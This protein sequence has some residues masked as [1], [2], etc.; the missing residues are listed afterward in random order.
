MRSDV[1]FAIIASVVAF[2]VGDV[3]AGHAQATGS[4][5]LMQGGGFAET[6]PG[7][8][9]SGSVFFSDPLSLALGA[10][11]ACGV[12]L[13]WAK[14]LERRGSYRRGEEHGSSRWATQKEMASYS[15]ALHP[16]NNIILSRRSRKRFVDDVHDQ[17]TETNN[18]MLIVGGP[19][20]GKTRYYVKPNLYQLNSNYF[21]TDPKGTLILDVGWL[22]EEEGYDI[23]TFD[24]IDFTRS[25]HFNPI[26]YIRDEKGILKFVECLVKNTT[27]DKEHAG[28][29]FWENAEKLLYTALIG[30]LVAHCPPEDRNVGGLIMLLSLA[31]AREDDED[32]MSPLDMLF[33]EIET[34]KRLAAKAGGSAYDPNGRDFD[35]GNSSFEWVEIGKP[36]KPEQDFALSTY[37][38]FKVAAGKTMKSIMVSCNVRMKPFD[39]DEVRELLSYDEMDLGHLGDVTRKTVVFASMSDT[40]STFDFLFALLMHEAMDTLCEVALS[41][42]QGRLPRPVHFMFDEFANIGRIPDFERMITVTRSRNIA[43][44]MILQS[45]SQ[46]KETYGDNNASTI[47]NACDTFVYLGG[48]S[49][50]TNKEISE[51]VGKQTVKN[52]TVNDSRGANP[53]TTRNYGVFERDLI[54]ASEIARMPR[55]EGLVLINGAQPFK[56]K[57]YDLGQH[58]RAHS[59]EERSPFDFREYRARRWAYERESLMSE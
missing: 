16:D 36:L 44:S 23:V 26:S 1:V 8:L 22:F 29:P 4:N 47:I 55:D 19:G 9:A 11:L 51:M 13:I 27:G 20:T 59:C 18:N 41:R 45:L 14:E 53:S 28:D 50:E 52:V 54:Q 38:Q 31:D 39:I 34:G 10:A 12:W 30:Y 58:P 42:Y 33:N 32:Y 17:R 46:L 48:K 43:V 25:M 3:M 49:N 2:M 37:K 15:D 24:T 35:E 40:D 7:S 57:K 5:P 21:I 6:L 56:D